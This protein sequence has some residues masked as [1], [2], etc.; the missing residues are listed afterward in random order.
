LDTVFSP[1]ASALGAFLGGYAIVWLGYQR[2]F[3]IGGAVILAA[4]LV[5]RVFVAKKGGMG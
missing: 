5:V 2:L 3:F 4:M 1:L